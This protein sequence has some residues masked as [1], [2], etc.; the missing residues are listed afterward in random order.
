VISNHV[1]N[2][3]LI[4][5]ILAGN[6]FETG[7]ISDEQTKRA[8]LCLMNTLSCGHFLVGADLRRHIEICDVLAREFGAI[9]PDREI[10]WFIT[11]KFWEATSVFSL[12]LSAGIHHLTE[13]CPEMMFFSYMCDL[14][15]D[16]RSAAYAEYEAGAQ[17][18]LFEI[19]KRRA[20]AHSQSLSMR[21][22]ILSVQ[23]WMNAQDAFWKAIDYLKIPSERFKE[24]SS[25]VMRNLIRDVPSLFVERE[26]ALCIE[27]EETTLDSHDLVDMQFFTGAIAYM[28]IVV[29]EKSFVNRA[30]QCKLDEKFN[31]RVISNLHDLPAVLNEVGA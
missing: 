2:G 9:V 12:D 8:R 28:D 14:P 15:S 5:P 11:R 21:R 26:L 4:V 30:M 3:T 16:T 13:R 25:T 17:N 20:K 24:A 1:A 31:T 10:D 22:R 7:K 27:A 19:Q 29:A 18:L 6:I 23:L